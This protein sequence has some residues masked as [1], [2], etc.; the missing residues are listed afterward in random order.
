MVTLWL[1]LLCAVGL[2]RTVGAANDGALDAGAIG[3]AAGV[4]ATAGP[5]GVI[6]FAWLRDDVPVTVSGWPLPPAAGL[7]SSAALTAG[8]AGTVL[9][10]EVPV[11][12]DEVT[13]A[14]DA[15]LAQS[16]SVT[17]LAPRL[18]FARPPVQVLHLEAQGD[19]VV[20]A[21]A[22]RS[23]WDAVRAVRQQAA[24]PGE[25]GLGEAP[26]AGALDSTALEKALRTPVTVEGGVASAVVGRDVTL[27]RARLGAAQGFGTR[28][29]VVGSD[30]RA[31]VSGEVAMGASEVQAVVRALRAGGLHLVGLHT[32]GVLETPTL[33]YAAFAG[34]GRAQALA[35]AVRGVLDAQ[36][37]ARR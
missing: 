34:T 12:E 14:V 4:A 19:G 28:V 33:W 36:Q 8:P 2:V 18:G 1:V 35:A 21:T 32:H 5:A 31:A 26:R 25:R 13:A 7:A 10:A 15:A 20:L 11:F 9:V 29:A 17:G 23:V 22:M 3:A 27:H 16:L 6:R 30:E 24:R 37:A